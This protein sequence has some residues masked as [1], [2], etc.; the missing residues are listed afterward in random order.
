MRFQRN[1]AKMNAI[2]ESRLTPDQLKKKRDA[3]EHGYEWEMPPHAPTG[4]V[5]VS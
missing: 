1:S 5:D 4:Q 2:N 3:E